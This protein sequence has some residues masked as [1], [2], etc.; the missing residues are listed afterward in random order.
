MFIFC[1]S[2]SSASILGNNSELIVKIMVSKQLEKK[3]WTLLWID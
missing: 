3:K 1:K 2:E